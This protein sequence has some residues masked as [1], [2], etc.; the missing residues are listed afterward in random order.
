MR[1]G[2]H[3][4]LLSSKLED[5]MASLFQGHVGLPRLVLES[6]ES[7]HIE[8]QPNCSP[9]LVMYLDT[10]DRNFNGLGDTREGEQSVGTPGSTRLVGYSSIDLTVS[11]DNE[12]SHNLDWT[13][14]PLERLVIHILSKRS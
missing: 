5:F 7:S 8:A 9:D 2:E 6:M 13:K 3:V 11:E 10:V 14:A 1:K 4:R 12:D